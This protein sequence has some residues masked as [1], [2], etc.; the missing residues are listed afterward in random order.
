MN[1]EQIMTG[2]LT[3]WPPNKTATRELEDDFSR[4]VFSVDI[5]DLGTYG[6]VNG[7][8]HL[9]LSSLV[10][11]DHEV[12]NWEVAERRADWEESHSRFVEF[13]DVKD[14]LSDLFGR[15]IVK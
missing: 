10:P 4:T 15:G 3:A 2:K 7:I 6:G 14:L 12:F 5:I 11:I 1:M 13:S 9:I 8:S